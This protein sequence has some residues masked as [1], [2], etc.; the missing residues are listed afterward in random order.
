MRWSKTALVIIVVLAILPTIIKL[1]NNFIESSNNYSTGK[2]QEYEIIITDD[3]INETILELLNLI[4]TDENGNITNYLNIV[5]DGSNIDVM[6]FTIVNNEYIRIRGD[7]FGFILIIYLDKPQLKPIVFDY[8]K[9]TLN[10]YVEETSL[11][12]TIIQ[13]ILKFIP[14]FI[15][16]GLFIYLINKLRGKGVI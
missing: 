2:Y 11:K 7:N 1:I 10:I 6:D 3:N 8:L 16:T 12:L 9:I 5:A 4:E 14:L 15:P 13:T